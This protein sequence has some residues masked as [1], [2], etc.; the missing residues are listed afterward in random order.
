MV[1]ILN[2]IW[3]VCGGFLAGVAWLF[4][5]LCLAVTI[6]GLPWAGAAARIGFFTL[7]PFGRLIVARERLYGR[8]DLGTGLVGFLLNAIWLFPLGLTLALVHLTL[9]V[10]TGLTIIGL[11][12]AWQHLKLVRLALMPVGVE[13]IPAEIADAIDNQRMRLPR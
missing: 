10:S 3:L 9:A 12:F 5:A 7:W 8:D 6:I 4:F 2:L 11:P 13:I 1:V